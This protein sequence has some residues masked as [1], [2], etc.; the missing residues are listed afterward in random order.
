MRRPNLRIH[1]SRRPLGIAIAAVAVMGISA[2]VS[3]PK[4][5]LWNASASVPV[6][7]YA[8][9]PKAP[10]Q[11]GDLAVSALP[12]DI[13]DLASERNYLPTDVLLIKPVGAVAGMTVCRSAAQTSVNGKPA[14]DAKPVDR[15][16]RPMP[17][18]SGCHHLTR[19]EIFLMNAT[20]PDSFDGRYFGPTSVRLIRGRAIPLLTFHASQP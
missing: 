17:V 19:R 18:W 16:R 5:L 13:R 8:V 11:V 6:G 1:R 12:P 4:L 2:F 20:V 7:L 14:G 9:L 10:V 3:A 15:M